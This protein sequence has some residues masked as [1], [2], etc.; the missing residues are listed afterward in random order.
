M[1]SRLWLI[2]GTQESRSLVEKLQPKLNHSVAESPLLI[3]VTTEPA[4][5]LYPAISDIDLWVG[6]L[7]AKQAPEFVAGQ[8]ISA[9]LD[10]SH[11]F[12]TEISALAIAL[13]QQYQLPYL[14]YE[15]SE[16][17]HS[18]LT[19]RDRQ[20]R[21]GCVVINQLDDLFADNFLPSER[22][23]LTLGY[24]LLSSFRPWQSQ[25]TLFARI[26][27]SQAALTAALAA[28]FTPDRLIALRPP[29]SRDLERSLWQQWQISQVV[30]KASGK[31][32]GEGQKRAIAAELG[33]RL[34][35]LA[36]PAIDYPQ[37]TDRLD[38]ALSFALRYCTQRCERAVI[39]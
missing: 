32:G 12:A 23:L 7:T 14:R 39:N 34:I 1:T 20:G 17:S 38:T 11:P 5:A 35:C 6:K 28:G 16:I 31:P 29:I 37:Q 8:Q 24:R 26:L 15:R 19:W 25:G 18:E 2:G 22:T 33:V 4:R 30:T 3:S 36:R 13:A 10:M 27:P 9:I 21:P